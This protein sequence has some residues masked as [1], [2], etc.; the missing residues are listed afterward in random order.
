MYIDPHVHCR[1][2]EH[3]YKETIEHALFVAEK[4]GFTAILDMPNTKPPVTTKERVIARLALAK[5]AGSRVLYGMHVML[6][7][8][9][10]QIKRSVQT[11][12]EFERADE[13]TGFKRVPGFKYYAGQSVGTIK[14]SHPD[15]QRNLYRV[16]A[17]EG[18]KGV[19][20]V[21][22]EKEACMRNS[23]WNPLQP[24]TH[25]QARPCEA[26][27][28]SLED[29][30]AFAKEAKFEGI[31]HVAHISVPEAVRIINNEKDLKITCGSTPHHLFLDYTALEKPRGLMMKMNPPLRPPGMNTCMQQ[32]LK[33]GKITWVETDH[34]PHLLKQKLGPPYMSGIT[35]LENYSAFIAG[36]R[37]QGFTEGHIKDVTFNNIAKTYGFRMQ[38]RNCSSVQLRDEY[39]FDPYEGFGV[40]EEQE[41]RI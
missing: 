15:Q 4:A 28:Q 1:D 11:Y 20:V 25:A 41:S 13:D 22:C 18:Y 16:L 21:H 3:A 30:I 2:W 23:L 39:P 29:Q 35:G 14:V 26:E 36:L 34:A 40:F 19:L 10:E 8:H 12:H 17:H 37:M 27:I 32:L 9:T 38:P 31:I 6:T 24:I 5:H 33:E 7:A